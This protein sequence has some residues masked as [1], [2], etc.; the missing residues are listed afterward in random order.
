MHPLS[1][2]VPI[3]SLDAIWKNHLNYSSLTGVLW[4]RERKHRAVSTTQ[5]TYFVVT[6]RIVCIDFRF[7][8]V[9]VVLLP[10][11]PRSP[12]PPPF[13]PHL[14]TDFYQEIF[15]LSLFFPPF[16]HTNREQIETKPD[17][18]RYE[19]QQTVN[20]DQGSKTETR[21]GNATE[22]WKE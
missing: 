16:V 2:V 11:P 5:D 6:P 12:I 19:I 14:K 20:Q 10:F 22:K 7:S 21:S 4:G 13:V 17:E 3:Q 1:T 9:T 15:C 18:A 8:F